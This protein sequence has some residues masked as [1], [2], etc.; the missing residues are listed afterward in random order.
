MLRDI[1]PDGTITS[2]TGGWLRASLREVDPDHSR[3]GAPVIPCRNPQAVPVGE[4]VEYRIPLV[5]NA[6]R[7]AAGHRIQLM[8]TSDDQ[9]K[10]VP[11]FLGYRHSPVGTTAR[12]TIHAASRLLLPVLPSAANTPAPPA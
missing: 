10:D 7:F 6:R 4:P 8:I 9:P 1:G 2:I 11:V 3:T 12:N 5:P